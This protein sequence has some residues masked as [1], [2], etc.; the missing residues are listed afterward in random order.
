[1]VDSDLFNLDGKVAIVTGASRGIGEA[2]ARL[3]A[4]HGAHVI[5]S[6]RKIEACQAV[7]D[8]ICADGDSA[9]AVACHIGEVDAIQALINGAQEKHGKVD[10]LVNNAAANPYLGPILDTD[11]GVYQ[12]TVDV[13]IRGYFFASV[14]AAKIMREQGGGSIVNIA[15]VNGFRPG[16]MQGIYSITKAAIINMTQSF[17]K[18]LA[19]YDI[20][21]NAV[22]PGF[23]DT[24]MAAAVSDDEEL[25]NAIPMKRVAQP[26][27]ISGAVLYLVSAASSYAT[28]TV[29]RVDGGYLA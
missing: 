27:E 8:S 11:L 14:T 16:Y 12:K 7:A 2:S 17:A 6:S 13:N 26:E 21:V 22:A 4:R 24:K 28:G 29:L 5:I 20:R 19:E 25:I 10:I 18:E 15:S 23:T 3:L 9:E 1:M